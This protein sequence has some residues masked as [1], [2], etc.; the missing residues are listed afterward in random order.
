[1]ALL[2]EETQEEVQDS[3]QEV[4]E[5]GLLQ[6][7]EGT[8]LEEENAQLDEHT[9]DEESGQGGDQSSTEQDEGEIAPEE[10]ASEKAITNLITDSG[11]D[12]DNAAQ[13]KMAN[14]YINLQ[15][16]QDTDTAKKK[17]AKRLSG[18]GLEIEDISAT[19][20][21]KP[22]TELGENA[23]PFKLFQPG[24]QENQAL[25]TVIQNAR[26]DG[27]NAAK[28]VL[29][30]NT[31]QT[32]ED[33]IFAEHG[34]LAEEHYD[35]F[36]EFMRNDTSTLSDAFKFYLHQKGLSPENGKPKRV[37]DLASPTKSPKGSILRGKNV[38][39]KDH[40]T[41]S[42]E[43]KDLYDTFGDHWEDSE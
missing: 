39:Q 34:E 17:K 25:M 26:Q 6:E 15:S 14:R 23:D 16:R 5:T 12:P 42:Q 29:D 41:P 1:M 37:A 40:R 22:L 33:R 19:D 31:I 28:K 27:I 18:T 20:L 13:R 4:S 11:G 7:S 38:S 32:Q 3:Q 21:M 35:D 2:T 43:D 24:T 9:S 8:L 10:S 30:H 36:I